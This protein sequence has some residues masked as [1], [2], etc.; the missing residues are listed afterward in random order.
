[1]IVSQNKF[2]SFM[3][4]RLWIIPS[5]ISLVLMIIAQHDFIAFHV[6]VE[7]FVVLFS[8]L[9]FILVWSTKEYKKSNFL[10]FIACGYLWLGLLN[11]MHMLFFTGA[12][13]FISGNKEQALQFGIVIPY[14]E[15]LL[16]F[17]APFAAARKRNEYLLVII[18]GYF[19]VGLSAIILQGKFASIFI[20]TLNFGSV[21]VDSQFLIVFILAAALYFTFHCKQGI[22]VKEKKFI[23]ASIV[24]AMCAELVDVFY[25]SEALIFLSHVFKLFSFWLILNIVVLSNLKKPFAELQKNKEN[26][27][28]LFENSEVSIWNEDFSQVI[29]ALDNLREK[30]INDLEK[31]LKVNKMRVKKLASLIKINQVNKATLKLFSAKNEEEFFA[32][33]LELF[34]TDSINVFRQALC[35]IWNDEKAFRAETIYRTLDGR[36]INCII[37]FQI[38]DKLEDFQNIPVTLVD[39]TNRKKNEARIWRQGNFDDLTGLVNRNLFTDRLANA[40]DSAKRNKTKLALLYLDLDGFKHINDTLGHLV[41]DQ[42]LKEVAE[43]LLNNIRKS[44]TVARL[45]GDEFAILL[46]ETGSDY[47]IETTVNKIQSNLVQPFRL[48]GNDS[49]ISASIGITIY[50]DDG[51]DTTTLLRK[52]DSA[53]YKAKGNGRNNFQFFTP[54]IDNALM[55]RKELETSLRVAIDTGGFFIKFQPV[56]NLDTGNVESTEAL[57]RWNHPSKGVVSP[58][59][60]IPLAEE[61]GLIVPIGEWVLREACKEAMTWSV[62]HGKAPSVAV[63]VSSVQFENKNIAQLVKQV[64]LETGLSAQRLVLEI[65]ERLLLEDNDSILKQLRE[66]R[67][68]GV[69]LSID[70]FGTGYSSLSYLKKF[71]INILKID[72]SFIKHLP[73]SLEDAA[74]VNAILSMANSLGMKVV[75]EGIETE[76]QAI[77][78]R[79]KNCQSAQGY[80]YSQPLIK[81]DFSDYLNRHSNINRD[82]QIVNVATLC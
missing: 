54:E 27:K 62:K 23:M 4:W 60:F 44:D 26:F 15:A 75:A 70:D 59:D 61:I 2:S 49:F 71:P 5:C 3:R 7:F 63:N 35:A 19:A 80:L 39:I 38:A 25:V 66:I 31:Y 12:E 33:I 58:I 30:G 65:T 79:L 55:Y 50:P 57:I 24:M 64:L 16:L 9:V 28:C 46:P 13:H 74:L 82:L 78:M 17:F 22:E 77:F 68:L 21:Q 14:L 73:T 69:K 81:N 1:M 45:G 29:N 37:S 6:L 8:L 11:F 34:V 67:K 72:R 41:G 47:E 48:E 18:F 56:I 36:E 10:I 52:A 20:E 32:R 40:L 53:M 43:R 42:L 76:E 51:V